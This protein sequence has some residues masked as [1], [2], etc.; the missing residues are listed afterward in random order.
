MTRHFVS[1][2][3]LSADE[4][5]ALLG[6]A[7][8]MKAR[9]GDYSQ[10]LAG[11]VLG[12]LFR[13][14][15]TRTRVSFEAGIAKLG[16]SGIFLHSAATQVGRGEPISDTGQVMSRY[17]DLIMIRTFDH[18]ETLG[19]ATSSR[20]PVINGLDDLL[21]PCQAL[22]DLLTIRESFGE[23]AG[24]QL[25]YVGDGNN[26]AHSLLLAGARAGMHVRIIGPAG[27]PPNSRV[28]ENATKEAA[29]TGAKLEVTTEL[30]AVAGAD[31]VY[32][33]VWASMGQEDEAKARAEK[34]QGYQVDATLMERAAEHAI[35]LHCLPAHRGEEVAAEVI[36]GPASRVFDQAENRMHVQNALMV[37]LH[38]S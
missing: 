37:F 35:F 8:E 11:K 28:L 1:D 3:D 24:R 6:R 2:L 38:D 26:V 4:Q 14:S 29:A 21:H 27:H 7:A 22:A 12:M 13:K 15:S 18:E 19:L 33:D 25:V 31:V 34:F 20:V 5:S 23:L 9:P 10:A 17:V 16:G 32:T 30:D 36:D